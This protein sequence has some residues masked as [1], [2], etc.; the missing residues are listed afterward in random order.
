MAQSGLTDGFPPRL[1]AIAQLL[2]DPDLDLDRRRQLEGMYILALMSVGRAK[3]AYAVCRRV[4]PAVPLRD[5]TQTYALGATCVVGLETGED[6]ADLEQYMVRT[7]REGIRT[8]DHEAAGIA[9]FTLGSLE[10]E[11]GRYR[12]A[13]RWLVEAEG[14]LEHHDTFDTIFCL[15]ALQVGIACFTGDP[16]RARLALESAR[17]RLSK[18]EP[19]FGQLPYISCAEGWGARALSESAGAERFMHE[20]GLAQDP[21]LRSR[22]L[23]EALRAG[24]RPGAVAAELTELAGR[25]DSRLV[26][27]RAAHAGARAAGDGK[28]LEAAGEQ[29]AA[30]GAQVC[31]ME[32]A[33]DAARQFIAEGRM[34]SARRAAAVARERHAPD[35]GAEF[36]L[37][38]GLGGV[39]VEL[40]PREAQIAALAARG[41][42]NQ[43]I[44]DQIVLSVRSVETY[45]YRA[46]QKRG[47]SN[48]R[49][50]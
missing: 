38:D 5:A 31:A 10:M 32:A 44:A 12:D 16:A 17:T 40:S 43:E 20:A 15:R 50:L 23:Y 35:H 34:A 33:V 37:I 26:A 48:R 41:L 4:R 45:V 47:V 19:Q 1:E 21:S 39:A 36:P 6:W 27:A 42:S 29:L 13:E 9:A 30:L 46:M 7:L 25:C 28:A 49:Q 22:L 14:E 3:E 2:S 11:R 18:R 8:G 24:A